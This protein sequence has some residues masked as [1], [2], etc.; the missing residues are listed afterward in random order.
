MQTHELIL[1]ELLKFKLK[2]ETQTVRR[3]LLENRVAYLFM[4]TVRVQYADSTVDFDEHDEMHINNI[5]YLTN[6]FRV[7][8]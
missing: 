2:C 8:Y 3:H 4:R 6:M 7:I 5:D 1:K